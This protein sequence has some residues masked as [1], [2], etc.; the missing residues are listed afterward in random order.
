MAFK[1]RIS[2]ATDLAAILSLQTLVAIDS[3]S[4]QTL[5]PMF[6][7]QPSEVAVLFYSN[8]SRRPFLRQV[9]DLDLLLCTG[10]DMEP[11]VLFLCHIFTQRPMTDR[12]FEQSDWRC[13]GLQQL[14]V[15]Q[16]THST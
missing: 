12:K 15:A 1:H 13:F 6:C 14:L 4:C 2:F 16:N 7:A 3:E 8:W 5:F 11:V 10:S 9:V